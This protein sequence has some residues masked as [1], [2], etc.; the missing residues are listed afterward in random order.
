MSRK[1]P[2]QEQSTRWR[3][4]GRRNEV[5]PWTLNMRCKSCDQDSVVARSNNPDRCAVTMKA[6]SARSPSHWRISLAGFLVPNR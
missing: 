4:D 6:R 2:A 3:D 5:V 1:T